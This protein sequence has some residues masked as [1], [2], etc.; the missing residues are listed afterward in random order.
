MLRDYAVSPK[1]KIEVEWKDVLAI[2][3]VVF[4]FITIPFLVFILLLSLWCLLTSITD[5]L[6][7]GAG[8]L[9]V[10]LWSFITVAILLML[11]YIVKWHRF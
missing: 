3:I 5:Y 7:V 9:Y 1:R 4:M 8:L 2:I 10:I 6:K 11:R